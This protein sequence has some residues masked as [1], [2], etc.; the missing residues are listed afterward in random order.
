MAIFGFYRHLS[1]KWAHTLENFDIFIFNFHLFSSQYGGVKFFL[2]YT[3][4][5]LNILI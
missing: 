4:F 2:L 1:Q 3:A 5:H